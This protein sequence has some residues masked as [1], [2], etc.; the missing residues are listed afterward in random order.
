MINSI[1]FPDSLYFQSDFL[2][3]LFGASCLVR[4]LDPNDNVN[5]AILRPPE[6]FCSKHLSCFPNLRFVLS[7]T[8]GVSH[9]TAALDNPSLKVITLRD[10]TLDYRQTLTTASD[11]A[12]NLIELS[13]RN[14]IQAHSQQLTNLFSSDNNSFGP[15]GSYLG[16]AWQ[17]VTVGIL[18]FGRIGKAVLSRIPDHAKSIYVYDDDHL[19]YSMQRFAS[20]NIADSLNHLFDVSDVILVSVTDR[21]SNVALL[22]PDLFGSYLHSVVNI[23]RPYIV[24]DNVIFDL[25]DSN[26]LGS[27]FS[28]FPI[29]L[30]SVRALNYASAGRL[31]A[32]PHLG[33]CTYFSWQSSL[34]SLFSFFL[35]SCD[36]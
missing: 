35:S 30:N 27:Y 16:K 28:D 13:L 5:V 34:S 36:Q 6:I 8:T 19:T 14:T 3:D 33:G 11:H 24:E 9:L 26:L 2:L 18:G 29:Q 31:L 10:L 23:S 17:E 15:R 25:F 4:D 1:Y 21:P 22:T 20:L 7:D 12:F 32:L